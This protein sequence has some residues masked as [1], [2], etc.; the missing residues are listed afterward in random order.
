[1]IG[2]APEPP[3]ARDVSSRFLPWIIGFMVFLATLAL[4]LTMALSTSTTK[5]REALSGTLTVQIIPAANEDGKMPS[6]ETRSQAAL[7]LLRRTP[8]VARAEILPHEKSLSLLE[9][10]LGRGALVDELPIP[11]LIDV[12]IAPDSSLD[13]EALG[14]RLANAVPG[15]VLDDHGV[16]LEKLLTLANGIEILAIGILTLIAAAAVAAVVFA[17]RAGLAIHHDV[18][19]VLHLIGAHDRYVARLFQR[20]A[21]DLALRGGAVGLLCAALTLIGL[22]SLAKGLDRSLL[23]AFTLSTIQWAFL[24][25]VPVAAGVIGMITARMTVTRALA[26]ML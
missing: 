6:L 5:W 2:N 4:A 26:R 12:A 15:A 10:W 22:G 25:A 9:P 8:G 23:P 3:L 20:R 21:L 1:M 16:W 11:R 13:T 19:E 7:A 24:M 17:T 18:V 14:I